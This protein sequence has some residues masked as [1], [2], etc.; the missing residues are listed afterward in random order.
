MWYRRAFK[1][2]RYRRFHHP[3][4]V[5]QKALRYR[6]LLLGKRV[7]LQRM[8]RGMLARRLAGRARRTALWTEKHRYH[9]IGIDK[10]RN[11]N[12]ILYRGGSKGGQWF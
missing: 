1:G 7:R 3:A 5:I 12:I 10:E 2:Y 8:A 6:G 11:I 9:R 4:R